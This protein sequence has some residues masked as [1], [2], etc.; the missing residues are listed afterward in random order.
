MKP[1]PQVKQVPQESIDAFNKPLKIY[2]NEILDF[3][4]WP[5]RHMRTQVKPTTFTMLCKYCVEPME[6]EEHDCIN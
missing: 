3:V 2:G 6:S 4:P 5:E 1:L